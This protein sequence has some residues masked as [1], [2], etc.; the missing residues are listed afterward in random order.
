MIFVIVSRCPLCTACKNVYD[1]GI[2]EEHRFF[3]IGCII[4]LV[5]GAQGHNSRNCPDALAWICVWLRRALVAIV[6]LVVIDA[7][8][9]CRTLFME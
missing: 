6:G 9:K 3:S 7:N 4:G 8:N 1:M 5:T 2:R